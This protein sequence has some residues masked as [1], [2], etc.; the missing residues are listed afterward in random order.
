MSSSAERLLVAL[1]VAGC[2]GASG[3]PATDPGNGDAGTAGLDG[4]GPDGAADPAPFCRPYAAAWCDRLAAC[5]P[6]LLLSLYGDVELCRQRRGLECRI[7]A[8]RP[9][10]GVDAARSATCTGA[11]PAASC[12][13]LLAG[14]VPGCQLRGRLATGAACGAGNQCASGYCRLPETEPCGIC[15]PAAAVGE[16]CLSTAGC[17]FPLRCSRAGRCAR[18]GRE[19]DPCSE[20]QPCRGEAFYC[21]GADNS[22]R[23]YAGP[24][25][26]CN[27]TGASFARP[28]DD[29]LV[30]RP[31]SNGICVPITYAAPGD[32]CGV[33]TSGPAPFTFCL[34]SASC[35][36]GHC[37]PPGSDG[38]PCT[39]SPLGEATGCLDPA[40]CLD[41]RCKLPVADEC[42]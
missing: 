12:E 41:G 14:A 15:A 3:G 10:A 1:L 16:P 4:P 19:A 35:V 23:P 26:T 13:D 20:T 38:D 32:P 37:Q 30:C 33:P 29:G 2:G 22:C 28:C 39:P 11:L 25:Q 34:A 42:Q 24:G 8:A 36:E 27:R 5:S 7:D 17:Q 9:G 31:G 6:P 40:Q 21:S 18:A